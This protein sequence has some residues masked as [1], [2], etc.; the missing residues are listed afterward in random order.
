MID[1]KTIHQIFTPELRQERGTHAGLWLDKYL[2]DQQRE[3]TKSRRELVDEVA[4]Q[5]EP[6]EYLAF[7]TRWQAILKDCRAQTRKVR[8]RGR[9]VIGLGSES[10]LEASISLHRTYGVPYIP[11]SALK[12]LAASYAH[13]R[14]GD[15]W[16][17]G[18]MFHRV[19]FGDADNAGYI[20]F[21]D[22]LYIPGTEQGGRALVPDVI[23]VHHQKYYQ[24]TAQVPYDSD[25]PTPIPFLSA[26]GHYLLAL[27]APDFEQPTRWIDITFQILAEALDKL[28]IGAKTSSGYG[29]IAF[30]DPPAKPLDPELKIAQGYIKEVMA[31]RDV[32]GQI[33]GY[34]QKWKTLTSPEAR[35]LL[36]QALI[37]KVE[38]AG[39][40]KVTA[41][42][43]WYKELRA[44]LDEHGGQTA[45]E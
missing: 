33:P 32:A 36:A 17:K 44:F 20:T 5:P 12:G 19:V 14:L 13:H 29:R 37:D 22:G 34:Y 9:M 2:L 1:Q 45:N 4:Q 39:R 41:E 43:T 25:D 27:S 24:N 26:T 28:G 21:F 38:Q 11:A 10:L 16:R 40:T 31:L 42:K 3:D 23:T 7:F 8:V 30:I 15:E 35:Q 6:A 18:G